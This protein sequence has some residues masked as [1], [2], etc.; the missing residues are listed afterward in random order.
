VVSITFDN[1]SP[2]IMHYP[3]VSNGMD[4]FE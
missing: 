2:S 4:E 1:S 3:D